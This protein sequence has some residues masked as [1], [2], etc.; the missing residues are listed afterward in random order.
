MCSARHQSHTHHHFELDPRS[1]VIFVDLRSRR[2]PRIVLCR[3]SP[4][5]SNSKVSRY[6]FYRSLKIQIGTMNVLISVHMYSNSSQS[7]EK[8]NEMQK[9][10]CKKTM[11]GIQ[12]P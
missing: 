7:K 11:L 9:H 3:G 2:T 8:R 10:K 1:R 4:G 5:L 12:K 6:M